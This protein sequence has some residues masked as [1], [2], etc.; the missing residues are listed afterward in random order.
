MEIPYSESK[1]APFD[2]QHGTYLNGRFR[3]FNSPSVQEFI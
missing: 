3:E 1:N 2:P